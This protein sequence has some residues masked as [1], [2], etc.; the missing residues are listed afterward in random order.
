MQ[1]G[2]PLLCRVCG[3][4]LMGLRAARCP[5]C[6]AMLDVFTDR[7][8]EVI[9]LANRIA[10]EMV[11]GTYTY[12]RPWRVWHM[13]VPTVL[14]VQP[15]HILIGIASGLIGIGRSILAASIPDLDLLIREISMRV[16]VGPRVNVHPDARLTLNASSTCVVDAAKAS[17]QRLDRHRAPPAGTGNRW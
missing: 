13:F 10:V 14:S 1:P 6:G 5:A 11:T 15:A 8:R 16:P 17:A 4:D 7:S 12:R 2:N 3:Y 9:L